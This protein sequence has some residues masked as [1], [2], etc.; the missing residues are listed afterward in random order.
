MKKMFFLFIIFTAYSLQFATY[1][2]ADTIYTKDNK[3]IKGIIIEE[4]K[5]RVLMSTV[6]GE[7]TLMKPDIKEL[8]FDT[9]E[10]NL[11]KLAEQARDRGD[12]IKAF[13]YYD[14]A[15]KVNPDS[16]AAK[17]GIVFLQGYL[18]K[19][20]MAKKEED[21]NR[22]NEFEARGTGPISIKTEEEK[23]NES[24]E[25]LKKTA[26]IVLKSDPSGT[27]ISSVA[28]GSPSYEA[29]METGD[30]LIAI[31]GRLVGYLSLPEVV[32]TLLEKTSLETKCTIERNVEVSAGDIG[33]EFKMQFDGLTI[34]DVKNGSFAQ[35][36]GLRPND[37]V[38][39]IN[40]QS[41]RYMPIKK[42]SELIKRS[43]DGI[44][45]LTI[46]REIV[47][48]GKEGG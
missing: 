47:M 41:T 46:R 39:Y 33:A 28:I 7:R 5:D 31:W 43:K 2:V 24:L 45:R 14:K 11:V 18:F 8:Y 12:L 22:R 15:F 40:G 37:L 4:Y 20:D 16:K 32:E 17:D 42:A 27:K 1:A 21:V 36:A 25:K 30:I 23:F 48:W 6:D 10:Q 26:G 35:G 38:T 29:G 44:I 3:E 34:S 13:V 9:E 19:K